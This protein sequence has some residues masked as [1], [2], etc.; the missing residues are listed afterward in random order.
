[1]RACACVCITERACVWFIRNTVLSLWRIYA[2]CNFSFPAMIRKGTQTC[3]IV[4]RERLQG[5]KS[6]MVIDM[7]EISNVC[8]KLVSKTNVGQV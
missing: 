8:E 7:G 1:M 6:C 3:E 2:R 5:N 4:R